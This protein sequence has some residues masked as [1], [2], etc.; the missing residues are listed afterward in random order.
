MSRY[1]WEKEVT[2]YGVYC[3]RVLEKPIEWNR[4]VDFVPNPGPWQR[5]HEKL[6]SAP[7]EPF[8]T[9][10]FPPLVTGPSVD[11][12]A[13]GPFGCIPLYG[14]LGLHCYNL[15]KGTNLQFMA[16]VKYYS[17]ITSI[18]SHLVTLEALDPRR[19]SLCEF[20]TDVRH[21]I[22]HRDCLSAIITCCRLTS[23]TPPVEESSSS[24][25][26]D[27]LAVDHFFR[28]AMPEWMPEGALTETEKLECYEMKESEVEEDKEWLHLYAEL[29]LFS[30]W[31]SKL[32]DLESA[33]PFELR[34]I[35][36]R[37]KEDVKPKNKV[38]ADNAIFYISFKT[39]CGQECNAIIR[40]T[41]DGM[42]ENL[43]LEVKCFM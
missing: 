3:S 36:V 42:P 23:Q 41:T 37:T 2:I 4:R 18:S 11:P 6:P 40:K 8:Y 19:N 29:A 43:S 12:P 27:K 25:C 24:Y 31:K 20:K 28:G 14:R 5:N 35:I 13:R 26:F 33:K 17:R 39:C 1:V 34:K 16:L 15:Q 30:K 22:E 10:N 21:A 7:E 32:E 9:H 38:K